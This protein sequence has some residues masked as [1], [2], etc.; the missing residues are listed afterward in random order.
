MLQIIQPAAYYNHFGLLAA[1]EPVDPG[2][3]FEALGAEGQ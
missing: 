1:Q 3:G 2:V